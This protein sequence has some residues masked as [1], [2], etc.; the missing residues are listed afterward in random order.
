MDHF[1]DYLQENDVF[2]GDE[3]PNTFEEFL[4]PEEY[5]DHGKLF[6]ID[7]IFNSK[8]ELVDWAKETAMKANTYLIINQH[9]KSRTS[10]RRPYITLAYERGDALRKNT[11]PRVDNEEEE[12]PT[13]KQGLTGQKNV[14]VHLN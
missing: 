4:E 2:E 13:K 14:G 7:Q 10:D 6:K 9:L 1:E 8:V 11:K 5:I 3:D 12:V